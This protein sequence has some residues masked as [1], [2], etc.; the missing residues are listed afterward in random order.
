MKI[1]NLLT[2]NTIFYI[3]FFVCRSYTE[4][5]KNVFIFVFLLFLLY[6]L[7]FLKEKLY[8]KNWKYILCLIS[9]LFYFISSILL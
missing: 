3:L 7:S 9:G 5:L 1:N 4:N 6:V 8:L 2:L